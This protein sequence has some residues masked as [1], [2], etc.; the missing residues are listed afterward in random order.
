MASNLTKVLTNGT[1]TYALTAQEDNAVMEALMRAH[2]A[3]VADYNRALVIRTASD[4]D[5]GSPRLPDVR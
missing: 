5:R 3:G 1:A 4:F 2:V